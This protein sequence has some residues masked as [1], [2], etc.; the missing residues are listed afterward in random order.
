MFSVLSLFSWYDERNSSYQ[1]L[2]YQPYNSLF[3][4]HS[5]YI[6]TSFSLASPPCFDFGQQW[7]MSNLAKILRQM[8]FL[9]Q[10]RRVGFG[11]RS[12]LACAT[13]QSWVLSPSYHWKLWIMWIMLHNNC[14]NKYLETFEKH[15]VILP[16]VVGCFIHHVRPCGNANLCE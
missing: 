4:G 12:T 2:P 10:F 5:S 16:D 15:K 7:H 13:H 8:L 11:T 6:P 3:I 14:L 9:T 1:P